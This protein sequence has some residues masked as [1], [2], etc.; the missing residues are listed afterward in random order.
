LTWEK[1]STV[2]LETCPG[3]FTQSQLQNMY[4]TNPA[5]E[6]KKKEEY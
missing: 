1:K 6:G 5:K 4:T 3:F 2:S